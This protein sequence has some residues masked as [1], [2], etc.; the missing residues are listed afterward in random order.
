MISISVD[1][2]PAPKGSRIQA[3]TKDGKG[4]T[5]PASKYE[6][7]WT[8]AVCEATRLVMRHEREPEKPYGLELAFRLPLPIRLRCDWPTAHDLD[9]LV[10]CVIDGLVQ[11][12][13]LA[14]DRHV[15][16]LTSSKRF[17]APSEQPGVDVIV[18]SESA[19]MQDIRSA[20]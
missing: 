15:T 10:R 12:G 3:Y 11:G 19:Q 2:R 17:C 7:P 6:K 5:R 18:R 9:K 1:G 20:A 13:A 4:Y 14:D 8:D 16:A